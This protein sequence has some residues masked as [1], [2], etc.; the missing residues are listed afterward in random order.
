M[1]CHLEDFDYGEAAAAACLLLQA[2]LESATRA[3]REYEQ[4]AHASHAQLRD[5]SRQLQELE[6][7][8]E[9][10]ARR[11]EAAERGRQQAEEQAKQQLSA[12]EVR[13]RAGLWHAGHILGQHMSTE[14]C[15]EQ[16]CSMRV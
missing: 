8:S 11:C 10:L 3:A 9:E 2:Q 5:A 12:V 14:T 15:H 1:A 6:R 4:A 16:Y 13:L 7:R